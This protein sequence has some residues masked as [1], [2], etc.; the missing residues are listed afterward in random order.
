MKVS[1]GLGRKT[2]VYFHIGIFAKIRVN[3]V[4]YKISRDFFHF[5][6]LPFKRVNEI[7][8]FYI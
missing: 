6:V 2:G 7:K 8:V 1:V 5:L 4:V 3:Y